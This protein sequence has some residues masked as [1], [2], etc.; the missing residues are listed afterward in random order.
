[1][2][3]LDQRRRRALRAA[4]PV[5]GLLAAGLLVWQGSYA[6]FSAT[7]SNT[8]DAWTTGNLV[9]TNNGG[10]GTG[11]AGSGTYA[12]STAGIFAETGIK[13]GV[14]GFKCITVNSG[15]SLAGTLKLYRGAVSGTNGTNLATALT[16]TV[17][18]V[19]LGTATS[20]VPAACTGYAGGTSGAVYNGTLNGLGTTYAGGAGSFALAGGTERVAYRIGWSLPASVTD[21]TLQGS[22]AQADLTWEVQ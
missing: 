1:M 12:A 22:T 21:N 8:N 4:A 3:R 7:T 6:A 20:N 14:S 18:A 19:A 2:N 16:V 9:L 11:T 5:A 15:G 10:T 13:P 17:D